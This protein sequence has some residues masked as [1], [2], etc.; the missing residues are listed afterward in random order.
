MDAQIRKMIVRL[1]VGPVC[2]AA[3]ILILAGRVDFL[4]LAR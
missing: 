1:L 2:L 3:M 4:V